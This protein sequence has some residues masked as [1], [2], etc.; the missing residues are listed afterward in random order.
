M[1][2]IQPTSTEKTLTPNILPCAI[3]HNG[4]ISAAERYWN[5]AT[6]Q[7]GT[8]TSYFRGRKLRGK[9]LALPESYEGA[10]LE[11]TEKKIVPKPTIPV[12]GED[13]GLEDEAAPK[14]IETL[15]MD[16]TATFDHVMVWDHEA[17]PDCEDVYVKGVEEWI[18]FAE[19]M[20]SY[21][22]TKTQGPS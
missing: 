9:K 18:G 6:E 13:G 3:K 21:D 1:L 5:P 22:T 14:E 11:K 15:I 16:K 7:D 4:P 2:A 17:V 12:P 10:I 19:A 8:S 20:H